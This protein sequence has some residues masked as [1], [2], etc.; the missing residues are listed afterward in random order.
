MQGAIWNARQSIFEL[1]NC[2]NFDFSLKFAQNRFL[3]SKIAKISIFRS[4]IGPK[5]L[6]V[7]LYFSILRCGRIKGTHLSLMP[8][9]STENGGRVR[10]ADI[11]VFWGFFVKNIFR[12]NASEWQM[13]YFRGEFFKNSIGFGI[14]DTFYRFFMVVEQSSKEEKRK[15][16]INMV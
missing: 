5:I 11:I 3:S 4:K 15:L 6:P 7:I 16:S 14:S 10:Q 13:R 12:Y 2:L 9:I 8:N 1:K